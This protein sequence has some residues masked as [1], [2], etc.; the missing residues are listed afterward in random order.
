MMCGAN[1]RSQN[2]EFV[3]SLCTEQL[4]QLVSGTDAPES[5]DPDVHHLQD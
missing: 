1:A 2:I 4:C 3:G 5:S